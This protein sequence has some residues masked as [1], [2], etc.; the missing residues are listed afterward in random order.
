MYLKLHLN[1]YVYLL[2]TLIKEF[3]HLSFDIDYLKKKY[4]F[5]CQNDKSDNLGLFHLFL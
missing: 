3:H 1:F 4:G 5:F 2:I